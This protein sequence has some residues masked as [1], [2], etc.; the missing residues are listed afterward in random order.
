MTGT[1]AG[2][3]DRS[4]L[5]RVIAVATIA[6]ASGFGQFGA[7]AAL[8][9]VA[10][11]F[12]HVV[13]GATLQDQAGLSGSKLG[14]GLAIIRLASLGGLPIASSADR[15]GR[16]PVLLGT[17]AV[18][19]CCT[20]A[21]SLTPTYWWFVAVFACGRPF[22]SA[23]NGLAGVMAA[24]ESDTRH[25]PA[26]IA[27]VAAGYGIGAGIA[28]IVHGVGLGFRVYFSL[29]LVP[30]VLLL[31]ASRAVSESRRFA[32]EEDVARGWQAWR[33]LLRLPRYR[34]RVAIVGMLAFSLSV[35]TGPANGFVFLYAENAIHQRAS[36]TSAMV[37]CSG[38]AGLCGLMLGNRLTDRAGRKPTAGMAMCAISLLGVLCY[39]GSQV[40]LIGGYI[41]A[42]FGASLLAPSVGAL[43]NELF[44][45]SARGL[46]AGW[47]VATGVL[48]AVCGLVVF[49]AVAGS[50]GHFTTAAE[51][52][53]LPVLLA[54][55]LLLVVPET[56]GV[57]IGEA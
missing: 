57:E 10:R 8:S 22:L 18:G 44:P 50:S 20:A 27:L 21:S 30:L 12:G 31:P 16:R 41:T 49:G 43:T 29:A 54:P 32:R 38:I 53:F 2:A 36:V 9:D 1:T 7:V 28:A 23:T 19:L 3:A 13:A 11:R 48:G 51:V 35:L 14:I 42:V 34:R 52:T 46:I 37:A 26:A 33:A 40:A 15:L 55:L 4:W 25:R 45:T 17:A 5:R 47:W 6:A 56:R 39:S 24:E